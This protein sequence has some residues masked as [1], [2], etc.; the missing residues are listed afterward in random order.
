MV[1]NIKHV[2]CKQCYVAA[3]YR[4]SWA[5]LRSDVGPEAGNV[6]QN[7]FALCLPSASVS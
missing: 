3:L 6:G 1:H 5:H 7:L 2:S 4:V